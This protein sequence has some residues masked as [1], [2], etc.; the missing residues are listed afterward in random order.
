MSESSLRNFLYG[1]CPQR[2][3]P[4]WDRVESSALGS[5]MA[6]G[7]FWSIGGAVISRGLMLF[8]SIL[9]ARMLGRE[10]YG[11]F[12]MIRTTLNM[13]LVFA[14]FGLGM[15]ATKHVAEFRVTDP[16]RAGRIMAISGLFAVG[17]GT[18]VA[19]GLYIFAPWL[20]FH[21][22]NAPHLVGELRIGA[23]IL[24]LNALNGAQTG[25]LA[26][27]EAFKAIAKV[28]LVVGLASFPLLVGGAYFGG[29]RGAVWALAVNM[30]INW[31]LNHLA[32]RREAAR[33]QVPFSCKECFTEWPILWRFSLPA[34]MSGIMLSPVL[35]ATNAMLVNQR[36]GYGQ[37]GLYDAANQWRMAILFI[38]GVV[39]QIV[40]PMLANLNGLDD[41]VRYRK[42]LKCNALINGCVALVV[43]LPVALLAHP[44]M[45]SYGPDFEEGA[46]SLAL[47]SMSTILV[48]LNS[49]VGQAIASK[50]RM[51]IGFIFNLMWATVFLALSYY[52][53]HNG[54]GVVGL[55]LANLIAYLAHSIW[56]AGYVFKVILANRSVSDVNIGLH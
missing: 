8:A 56:Q 43:A 28:N 20:A 47:L 9:V 1:A 44:I 41:Q 10:V 49:V 29:L 16:T 15:T 12:G 6:Q 18:L 55:A 17:T 48:A 14:G 54:Y 4:Y 26:G 51:W 21:T 25:A 22:I 35:W 32:L 50:G 27:F 40:L 33:H 13:F 52:F 19:L 36:G 3:L 39:G 46:L 45:R 23:F 31:L 42:A 5:R 11:E 7:A 34:A 37:M 53:I 38:P 30:I 24:L 2:L